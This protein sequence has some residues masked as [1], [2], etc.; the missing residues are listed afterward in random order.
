MGSCV[1]GVLIMDGHIYLGNKG[2]CEAMVVREDPFT[3]KLGYEILSEIHQPGNEKEL[4]KLE[5]RNRNIWVNSGRIQTGHGNLAVSRSI[6][7]FEYLPK[8]FPPQGWE[9]HEG[10]IDWLIRDTFTKETKMTSYD[11]Y[12][13]LFSDGLK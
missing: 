11:K 5:A 12:L 6:G 1:V 7:D 4:E 3:K 13:F 10:L 8:S 2:D 9:S